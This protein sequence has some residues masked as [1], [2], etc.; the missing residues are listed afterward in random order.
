[1]Q[2]SG[3]QLCKCGGL[4][5]L[6]G[7]AG[8][9]GIMVSPDQVFRGIPATLG[10]GLEEVSSAGGG[11]R[12]GNGEWESQHVSQAS[13]PLSGREGR[14]SE[15]DIASTWPASR[16]VRNVEVFEGDALVE[17]INKWTAGKGLSD[18]TPRQ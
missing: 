2:H 17:S 18:N 16:R 4:K 7:V 1:M 6:F 5:A 12:G 13:Q 3:S 15:T 14:P 11:E 9:K 8:V 10:L